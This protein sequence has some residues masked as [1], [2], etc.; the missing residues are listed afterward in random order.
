MLIPTTRYRDCET[1]LAFLTEVL[2]LSEHAVH[3]DALGQIV[4][5]ELM[6]G[7]GMVMFGP[8]SK[9]AFDQFMVD[10]TSVGGETTTIYGVVDDL[11]ARYQ[12]IVDAGADVVLPLEEQSYGG[13]NFSVRDPEGHV[14][15]FGDYDPLAGRG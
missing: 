3:R 5:A 1:A 12:R 2:G 6:L 4:H 11:A 14:W 13:G 8:W 10:P 9:G 15:S 7:Q